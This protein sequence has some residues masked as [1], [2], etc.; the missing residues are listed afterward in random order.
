MG[1]PQH[2]WG[3]RVLST[4]Q[5]GTSA[6]LASYGSRQALTLG[7]VGRMGAGSQWG[8]GGKKMLWAWRCPGLGCGPEVA[9]FAR[10]ARF[11]LIAWSFP[12]LTWPHAPQ[13]IFPLL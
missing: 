9:S 11:G 13:T 3:G 4:L 2:R 7:G 5:E 6:H 8:F 1:G 12:F 10:P